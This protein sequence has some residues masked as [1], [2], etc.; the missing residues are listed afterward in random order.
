MADI[1]CLSEGRFQSSGDRCFIMGP[2][3]FI[4]VSS[5][6]WEHTRNSLLYIHSW[7]WLVLVLS[8]CVFDLISATFGVSNEY[9]KLNQTLIYSLSLCATYI[10]FCVS[11]LNVHIKYVC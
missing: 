4:T 10:L 9:P 11:V 3:V 1:L 5:V 8:V 6:Y 2:R 7:S